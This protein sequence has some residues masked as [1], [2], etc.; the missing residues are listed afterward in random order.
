M[1]CKGPFF[2]W[3]RGQLFERLDRVIANIEWRESFPNYSVINVPLPQSDHTTLWLRLDDNAGMNNKKKPF[4]FLAPWLD[5]PDFKTQVSHTWHTNSIWSD[6]MKRFTE[7]MSH[8]N[9]EVF[10]NIFNRKKRIIQRLDGIH[11][12]PNFLSNNF[13]KNLRK[14]LWEDYEHIALQEE[15]YRFQQSRSKWIAMGDQNTRYFQNAALCRRKRNRINALLNEENS[16]I[17]DSN[18]LKDM[19]VN[20][21]SKLYSI[22]DRNSY[23]LDTVT[24][25]PYLPPGAETLLDVDI[26]MEEVRRALFSM[27]NLKSPGLDGLHALFY[28]SQWDHMQQFVY[29]FVKSVFQDPRCIAKVNQTTI[30][31]IPKIDRPQRITDFRPISLCNVIY[32]VVTKVVVN[33]VKPIMNRVIS[34]TQSSFV[35]G[36]QGID[37]VVIL[38]EVVHSI[39]NL[40]GRKGFMVIK[41]DL[42]K[43]YDRLRWDFIQETLYLVG[44]NPNL[45]NII[46]HCISSSSMCVNWQGDFSSVFY[47]ARG[48]RQGDPLSPYIFVLCMDK[49]FHLI[50]DSIDSSDWK[51]LAMGRGGPKISQLFF[52]DDII[53]V[54]EASLEQ[55]SVVSNIL[56]KFCAT[57]GQNVSFHKSSVFFSKNV[58][59]DRAEEISNILN[60]PMAHD[61]GKY[62]GIPI[63]HNKEAISSYSFIVEKV[64]KKLNNWKMNMLSFAGRITLAQSCIMSLPCYVMQACVIPASIC[65]EVEKICR[66]FIWGSTNERRKCHLVSWEVICS[67]KEKGGLGFRNLK[68]VNEAYM[69]K[70]AWNMI[71][72]PNALWSK[73]LTS[74]YKVENPINVSPSTKPN[75]SALWRGI[76]RAF[77]KV[78]DGIMRNMENG[79]TIKFWKDPWLPGIKAIADIP[80]VDVPDWCVNYPAV[81]YS[82]NGNWDWDILNSLLPTYVCNLIASIT[83]PNPEAGND[84]VAWMADVSG[85]FTLKSAYNLLRGHTNLTQIVDNKFDKVWKWKGPQRIRSFLWK[86]CHDKLLTNSERM[87]RN[88]GVDNSC[89]CCLNNEETILHMLRDCSINIPFWQR[90][91][92]E[93]SS[94][95]FWN[96]NL[97]T[98]LLANLSGK[99]IGKRDFHWETFFGVAV[100]LI[101]RNRNR[102]IFEGSFDTIENLL[103]HCMGYAKVVDGAV[104]RASNSLYLKREVLISWEAPPLVLITSLML[105]ALF[106][107]RL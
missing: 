2:T 70:L 29:N 59:S 60:I 86:I 46:M 96:S 82:L 39:K 13:L 15:A 92:H 62:L 94:T 20:Y 19:A 73:V 87:K 21:F 71:S 28:K 27:G 91:V 79:G 26:C 25:F 77:P 68:S 100:W 41:L 48:I 74:K 47:P 76:S 36:R 102:Q 43:A 93:S 78:R 32:K 75:V 5:H 104:E 53:L 106:A 64:R 89:P 57:S 30:T 103:A 14:K 33:R 17:Y 34:H 55:A 24:C 80:G 101:W 50:Q 56:Q 97:E 1:G 12:D 84:S 31:L 45:I 98:W 8:W 61:L 83:P 51:P 6:N 35:P 10:G 7:T 58:S 63:I 16:W 40:K 23:S 90:T 66:G 105:M 4:K 42:E 81:H 49:L 72:N 54:A 3:Q 67:P 9:R 44:L 22:D 88:M 95:L 85:C 37:N 65:Q 52:T 69:M 99:I 107:N 18:E 11:R 38:K